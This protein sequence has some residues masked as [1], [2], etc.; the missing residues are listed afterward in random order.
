[1]RPYAKTCQFSMDMCSV[2]FIYIKTTMYEVALEIGLYS[3]KCQVKGHTLFLSKTI[4][5][6]DFRV[7]IASSMLQKDTYRSLFKFCVRFEY[8]REHLN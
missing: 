3:G 6:P 4:I 5:S 1:M 2:S 8:K 7:K